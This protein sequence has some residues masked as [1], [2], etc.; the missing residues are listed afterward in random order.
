MVQPI[1]YLAMFPQ[2]DFL[3]DIQGGLQLGVGLREIQDKRAAQERALLAQQQYQQ[4]I[5]AAMASPTPQAFASLA[6]KYPQHREAFKQGW[7]TLNTEQQQ[8][9]LR[10]MTTLAASLK[11]NR[12]DV[13]LKRIDERIASMKN[14]GQPT[15]QLQFLRDQVEK[16][17]TQAYGS[18][19][20]VLS[21]VPGGD[22]ALTNLGTAEKAPAELAKTEAEA[23]SAQTAALFAAPKARAD[24]A[25]IN[26]QISDRAARLG[27]DQDKM[28]S[29]FQLK[30]QE[31][32]RKPGAIDLPDSALKIVNEA[33]GNSV[34]ARNAASQFEGLASQFEAADPASF[35]A[36][37]YEFLKRTTGQQDYVSSLRKEYVRLRSAEVSKMLPPGA[38]SDADVAQALS[39]FLPETANAKELAAFMRGLAKLNN[40]QAQIEEARSEW[41]GA[42]GN[43]GKAARDVE[44]GGVAVP[45][46]TT[47]A[48]FVKRT[49]KPPGPATESPAASAKARLMQKYGGG[50]SGSY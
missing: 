14:T 31:L 3:R 39:G 9:E 18:V 8:N 37:A 45:A 33:A 22:K 50:A 40:Y 27:M 5:S 30:V 7:E 2:Q 34:V 46:G 42:V 11:S 6:V 20:Q 24:I 38:A 15:D 16:N 41:A 43:L 10:D 32:R 21:G 19:L 12:P 47:F 26:S 28:T 4:D 48:E 49:Q 1:N 29:E 13:A 25:N 36:N 35:G 23:R 17:P 44:I